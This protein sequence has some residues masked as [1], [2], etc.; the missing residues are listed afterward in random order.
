MV[1]KWKIQFSMLDVKD[2][3]LALH[4]GDPETSYTWQQYATDWKHN[5]KPVNVPATVNGAFDRAKKNLDNL[6]HDMKNALE[7]YDKF[8]FPVSWE[9]LSTSF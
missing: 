9:T 7:G 8:N 2:G 5:G 6:V 4:P 1:A 3:G